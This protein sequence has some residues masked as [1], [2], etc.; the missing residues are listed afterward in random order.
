MRLRLQSPRQLARDLLAAARR[1]SA[2]VAEY[3]D[4][5]PEEWEALAEA[6]PDEVVI[7]QSVRKSKR[8]YIFDRTYLT[9]FLAY[10]RG[11]QL[12]IHLS[13]SDWSIPPRRKETLPE[14]E[15]GKHPM[16]FKV[17]SGTKA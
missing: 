12:Y 8:M 2:E 10:G 15:I 11:N 14:P 16:Q 1:D 5:K 13:R 3:L 6:T 4:S 7:A 17:F 9:N